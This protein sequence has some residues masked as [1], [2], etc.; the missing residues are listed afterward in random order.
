MA[1]RV[2]LDITGVVQGVGF[3]PAVA[4]IAAE[5]G[6]GG[7]VYNDAGSVHCELEGAADVVDAPTRCRLRLRRGTRSPSSRHN[8]WIFL[9]FASQPCSRSAAH[10]LR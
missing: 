4:R 2:R 9:R 6:L 5:H 3:R 8:R 10:A 7:F 1:V